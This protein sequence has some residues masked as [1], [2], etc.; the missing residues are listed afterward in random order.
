MP[1]K[2][3]VH[4]LYTFCCQRPIKQSAAKIISSFKLVIVIIVFRYNKRVKDIQD[5]AAQALATRYASKVNS[6]FAKSQIYSTAYDSKD[7]AV[8]YGIENMT[9]ARLLDK[10]SS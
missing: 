7:S 6:R 8:H 9:R 3:G 4:I 10:S 1:G 2:C 5:A